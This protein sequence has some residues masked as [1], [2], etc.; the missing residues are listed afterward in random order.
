MSRFE[1]SRNIPASAEELFATFTDATRLA[2]WWGPAGFTNTIERCEFVPGGT[3]VYVMHGPDGRDYP[4]ESRFAEIV[5][6][7]RV[8]VDHVAAP[9]FRLT[10]SLTPLEGGGTRVGWLQVFEDP[11]VAEA[12]AHIVVPANEQ[13]LERLEAEVLRRT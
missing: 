4:N 8:V 7:R 10:I 5:P 1:T 6:N 2:R 9:H 3:W 13:N 11:Q 12:I